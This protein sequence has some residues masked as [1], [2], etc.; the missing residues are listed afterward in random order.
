MPEN[1]RYY[2][3]G[4]FVLGA[5]LTA[6]YNK[7]SSSQDQNSK[8]AGSKRQLQQQQRHISKFAKINDLDNSEKCSVDFK[9][10]LEKRPESIKEG[11]EGCIG[12]TPLIKIKSLSEYTGC[13]ILAKAEVWLR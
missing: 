7:R 9:S 2:F 12:D 11:V 3:L 1:S 10:S 6:A 8:D 5:V 4:A 13:E